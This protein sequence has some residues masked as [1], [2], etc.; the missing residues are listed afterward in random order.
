LTNFYKFMLEHK[1]LWEVVKY[2]SIIRLEPTSL[3]DK[4][5]HV[6]PFRKEGGVDIPNAYLP[7][8]VDSDLPLVK[9][10]LL[11]DDKS[12]RFLVELG[13]TEPNLVAEVLQEVLPKYASQAPILSE[14][15]HRQDLKKIFAALHTDSQVERKRVLD[16]LRETAFLRAVNAVTKESAFRI[17]GTLYVRSPELTCY[18][19]GNRDA[20]FL[21]ENE[22]IED[23][24]TALGIAHT[25]RVKR[26]ESDAYGDVHLETFRRYHKRGVDRFDPSIHI[27]GLEYAL[28]HKPSREKAAF[29]WNRLLLPNSDCLCGTIESCSR[30]TFVGAKREYQWSEVGVLVTEQAWLPHPNDGFSKPQALSL[31]DLPSEFSKHET[32]AKLLG[33]RSSSMTTLAQGLG[34]APA[35]IEFF[36]QNKDALRD[37]EEC[38]KWREDRRK[39]KKPEHEPRSQ[40]RRRQQVA[41]AAKDAPPVISEV[42]PR[43]ERSNWEAQHEAR[44]YLRVEYTNEDKEL[45]CQICG[46]EMPFKLDAGAYYFEAI[47]CVRGTGKELLW[48][49]LALCPVCAA[50]YR[51]AHSIQPEEIKRRVLAAL[52][53]EVPITL[54]REEKTIWFTKVHLLDLQ[55]ALPEV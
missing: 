4:P 35:V 47:E 25:V 15:E 49:H 27:D 37:F 2:R 8:E 10:T 32:V 46:E 1:D 28:T 45:I 33:M 44:V 9:K 43:Q 7:G 16:R 42:R 23:I 54:A 26:R 13:L 34:I 11:A 53:T 52:T 12:K 30:Q 50:K 5:N 36:Q 3:T 29:I 19:E 41:Q 39:P 38:K 21:D 51:H 20:W 17:P 24:R 14:E 40:E 6:A 48:N 22:A 18:F 31:D 55:T